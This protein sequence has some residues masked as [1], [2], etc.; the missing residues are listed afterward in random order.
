MYIRRIAHRALVRRQFL[1]QPVNGAYSSVGVFQELAGVA[2]VVALARAQ[3]GVGDAD[4]FAFPGQF[5]KL[6][7]LL[8]GVEAA[9]LADYSERFDVRLVRQ[10]AARV[11]L[12]S[13]ITAATLSILPHRC[14]FLSPSWACPGSVCFGS[15]RGRSF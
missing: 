3:D 4:D 10:P 14:A 12:V 13:A 5:Q 2:D 9:L 11:V 7:E 6:F 8:D 1:Q 15:G